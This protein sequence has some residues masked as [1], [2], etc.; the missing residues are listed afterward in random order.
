ML[1]DQALAA[2][3][4]GGDG[5]WV[6]CTYGRGGHAS[7]LLALMGAGGRLLAFDKDPEAER[8]ALR[9]HGLDPR[10]NFERG[11][12]AGLEAALVARGLCGQ[13]NGVLMDL[14]VSS[15]QLDD[16][17]RGFSFMRSG[18]LDMRMDPEHGD[19][20]A[21]WLA[22]AEEADIDRVIRDYGEERYH[23]RIARAIV[24]GRAVSPI[25]STSQL[26]E[27]VARAMPRIESG[28][29]AAT[30]TFQAIRIYINRELDELADGLSQA[31]RVLAAGGRLVVISFHSLEDRIVKRFMR[32]QARGPKVPR[33]VP[34]QG[35]GARG[36]LRVVGKAVRAEAEELRRNPRARSAIMRVAERIQ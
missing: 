24:E 7:A 23:R 20:A 16:P 1:L 25:R 31:V 33:G 4:V 15:P 28:K 29:H 9:C 35:P 11:S 21:D 12:F 27:H 19:S 17:A 26:A 10:F 14:G 22:S 6:D 18:P 36:V 3:Q 8:Q 32:D 13:V 34:V 30:R 5:L 2:L